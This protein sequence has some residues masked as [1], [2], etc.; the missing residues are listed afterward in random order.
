MTN[1]I[2]L[3]LIAANIW[4]TLQIRIPNPISFLTPFKVNAYQIL[5]FGGLIESDSE[6]RIAY[7]SNQVLLFDIRQPDIEKEQNIK[8][9]FV[10]IYP[11]F[12]DEDGQLLLINEDGRS[13]NPEILF[14]DISKYLDR[15]L[16]F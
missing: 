16:I 1:T 12:Y 14:Y 7:P 15:S 5:L 8:K 2:E 3:Y 10:S 9:D 4:I 6:D 11:S 13:D